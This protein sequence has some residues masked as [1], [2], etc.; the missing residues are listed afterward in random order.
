MMNEQIVELEGKFTYCVFENLDN[1]YRVFRFVLHDESEKTLTVTGYFDE[2]ELDVN[3]VIQGEYKEHPRFG[4]Q[5]ACIHYHKVLPKDRQALIRYLSS[6][7]FVGIGQ[8]T[9]EKIVDYFGEDCL[10]LLKKDPSQLNQVDITLKQKNAIYEG[11]KQQDGSLQ[12]LVQFLNVQGIGI[13]NLVRIHKAYGDRS[14][15]VL[16][17]NP[18]R[19]IEDCDGF[20]FATAD[21]LAKYLGIK[22]HDERRLYALLIHLVKMGC[23]QLGDSYLLYTQV[24]QLFF[25]HAIQDET[26]FDQLFQKAIVKRQLIQEEDMVFSTVQ[27]DS[28]VNIA[29]RLM[30]FPLVENDPYDQQKLAL[31]IEEVEE[32]FDIHYDQQQKAAID[33]F[34]QED[35]LIV[36]GGPG[37]GKTTIVKALVKLYK[38]LYPSQMIACCAPTGRASKRLSQLTDNPATTI[39]SL[40]RWDLESNRFGKNQEDPILVDLLIIDEFS[41]V[42]TY[43]F[44]AILNASSKVRKLVLIGDQDQLP[45]VSAGCVLRDLIA[46][47][48][49]TT[50]YLQHIYRQAT[51]SGVV[52]LAHDLK[53]QSIDIPSYVHD[54]SFYDVYVQDVKGQI[55]HIV[56]QA[57]NEGY[58]LDDVQ[59]LSP[60]YQGSCGIDVLNHTL[61]D[62]FN[63]KD[64]SKKEI[65]VGYTIFREQD[66]ILQLKNQPDDDVYNGDIGILEEIVYANESDD[67]RM[68]LWVNYQGIYVE[69]TQ[70]TIGNLTLAYCIS[71]HK[72]QGCEYPMVILPISFQHRMMLQRKLLYTAITRARKN[73]VIIGE[74]AAF[75]EG[76]QIQERH[77]RKTRLAERIKTYLNEDFIF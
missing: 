51:G 33:H 21:K 11:L 55:G 68:H 60:M 71:I 53:Q 42:D 44:S 46:S 18:Y 70:E 9:A 56:Q 28:E 75:Q 58:H 49:F 35:V 43:L 50:I 59:V 3:Y 5:F 76:I 12:D 26:I 31:A 36:T 52:K 47:K 17:E 15:Q 54:V 10:E 73:L 22:E 66:K 64:R 37:T 8:K 27:Y 57:L 32:E 65:K 77:V 72:S 7:Q 1:Y 48:A 23:F 25:R 40:L 29:Q 63:P 61:Q 19:V 6:S 69:Y 34:F 74:L 4:M 20:G 62:L 41:M 24:K 39:H 13:R 45:S 38:K 14:L 30:A 2:I 16:H 67:H